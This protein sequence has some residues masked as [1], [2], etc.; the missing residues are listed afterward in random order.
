M[1]SSQ[2]NAGEYLTPDIAGAEEPERGV[3][4]CSGV[5]DAKRRD[6][7]GRAGERLGWPFLRNAGIRAG[8]EQTPERTV[9]TVTRNCRVDRVRDLEAVAAVRRIL[10]GLRSQIVLYVLP[11]I[12]PDD[13]P[14]R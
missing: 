11:Q 9:E 10:A 8:R 4:L 14:G 7:S 1:L 5:R 2:W 3:A 12:L 6:L 13:A